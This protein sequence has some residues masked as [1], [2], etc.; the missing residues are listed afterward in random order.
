MNT[1]LPDLQTLLDEYS[2]LLD[3]ILFFGTCRCGFEANS[4]LA[5]CQKKTN[6]MVHFFGTDQFF[7][8]A[9]CYLFTS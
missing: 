5:I 4:A 7:G 3:A 8:H 9:P 6:C 2:F 1:S